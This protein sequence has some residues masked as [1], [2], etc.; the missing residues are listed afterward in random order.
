MKPRHPKYKIKEGD[1]IQII[2]EL[3]GID[4]DIWLRYHNN[5][6]RLDDIIRDTLPKQLDEIYLL[7]ELWEKE[8][9]LNTRHS[10]M[11]E[12]QENTSI[13]LHNKSVLFFAP[14]NINN[15]YGVV[16]NLEKDKI[17]N[18]EIGQHT[19]L[20]GNPVILDNQNFISTPQN[21]DG[22]YGVTTYCK[23]NKIQ[24]EITVTYKGHTPSDEFIFYINRKQL[25]INDNEPDLLLYEMANKMS[26]AF[27]PMLIGINNQGQVFSIYNYQEIQERSKEIV[28]ELRQYYVGEYAEKYINNF[29][30]NCTNVN[31]IIK[32][33]RNE[34]F[35]KLFF[36]PIYGNYDKNLLTRRELIWYDKYNIKYEESL[37]I[38]IYPYYNRTGKLKLYV[39]PEKKETTSPF[40]NA[41][42]RLYPN[43][44]S[45]AM[46]I[47][48]IALF[49]V[50]KELVVTK[51]EIIH[52]SD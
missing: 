48:E 3:F 15:K 42:Y 43:D 29:Q 31:T 51:V 1:T 20:R 44:N 52:L 17:L 28:K 5:M 46:I 33:I 6:C 41:E 19:H 4:K 36:F 27:F 21:L 49:N 22:R 38:S 30:I 11:R 50:K 26:K 10:L 8:N 45:I 16:L 2:T 39:K 9:T 35:L 7:P 14:M 12:N 13:V 23:D 40:I 34:I 32:N 24:Y 25:Y 18:K 47:G 37:S